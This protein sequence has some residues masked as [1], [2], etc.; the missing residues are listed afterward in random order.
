MS[1]DGSVIV[2]QADAPT[3]GVHAVRWTAAGIQDLGVVP[4]FT[5][6][7]ALA[8]N[9]DGSVIGGRLSSDTAFVWTTSTGI[10]RLSDYLTAAGVSLPEGLKL[11]SVL[12]ISDDG[13]TFA[14]YTINLQT[15]VQEGFVATVPEPASVLSLT[16]LAPCLRR[17]RGAA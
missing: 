5:N 14:G 8:V 4:G 10:L 3:G 12:A 11:A 17:R 9:G 7:L 1:A 15:S 16:L 6:S 2:G 13:R